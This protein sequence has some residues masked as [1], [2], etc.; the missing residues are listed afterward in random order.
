MSEER[1]GETKL[2]R[3]GFIAGAAAVTAGT[4]TALAA[5]G[6]AEKRVVQIR[7]VSGSVS[8]LLSVDG[9]LRATE[10]LCETS[11]RRV[12][13]TALGRLES[14]DVDEY[15]ASGN[16]TRVWSTGD[17]RVTVDGE[18]WSGATSPEAPAGNVAAPVKQS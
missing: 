3:R 7:P 6:A 5:D 11:D 12:G 4:V 18:T 8:Y 2:L 16:I 17:V 15:Y 13:R 1:F 10:S 9:E 14:T